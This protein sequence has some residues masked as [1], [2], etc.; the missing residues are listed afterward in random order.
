[1]QI[2]SSGTWRGTFEHVRKSI[3]ETEISL[4][5][6]ET[7]IILPAQGEKLGCRTVIRTMRC[8]GFTVPVRAGHLGIVPPSRHLG[9][10]EKV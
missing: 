10:G 7:G 4:V 9:C 1:M 6:L 2:R 3:G 5:P 8:H